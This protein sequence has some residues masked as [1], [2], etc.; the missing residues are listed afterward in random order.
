[1][2]RTLRTQFQN[3]YNTPRFKNWKRL[4]LLA[5]N[6]RCAYCKCD[7]HGIRYEIDHVQPLCSA[8]TTTTRLNNYANLVITCSNCNRIKGTQ[9]GWIYPAWIKNNKKK[10]IESYTLQ[11]RYNLYKKKSRR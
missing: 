2:N 11:E 5:Q 8:R 6:W 1:M 7:L 9:R 3:R 10:L 4:Q